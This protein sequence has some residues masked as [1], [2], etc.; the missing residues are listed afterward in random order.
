MPEIGEL[1]AFQERNFLHRD[2]IVIT[3]VFESTMRSC[4]EVCLRESAEGKKCL[5]LIFVFLYLSNLW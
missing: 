5:F 3:E 1:W 4:A 2:R